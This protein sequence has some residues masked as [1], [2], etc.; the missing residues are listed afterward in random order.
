MGKFLEACPQAVTYLAKT[1][2]ETPVEERK[3]AFKGLM[4]EQCLAG[5]SKKFDAL[6]VQQKREVSEMTAD[7]CKFISPKMILHNDVEDEENVVKLR[8]EATMF[9]VLIVTFIY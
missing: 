1:L 4:S 3:E 8:V 2:G 5:V 7:E 6:E 9:Q